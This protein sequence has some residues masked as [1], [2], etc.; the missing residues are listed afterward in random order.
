MLSQATE[1]ITAGNK[2]LKIVFFEEGAPF[3][4]CG[5]CIVKG[6][7]KKEGVVEIMKYIHEFFT[8]SISE[9]FYPETILNGKTYALENFPTNISYAD[10]SGNNLDRK[11]A[12]LAKWKH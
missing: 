4:M 7:E 3:N 1:K 6:K 12:L 8:P 9:K 10:M 5:N 11:E 2:D